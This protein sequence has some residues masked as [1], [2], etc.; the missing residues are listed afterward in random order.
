[1]PPCQAGDDGERPLLEWL[2]SAVVGDVQDL[3]SSWND[4]CKLAALVDYL[5]PGLI[6][7]HASLDPDQRLEN[8]KRVMDLAERH[9]NIPQ[10]MHPED[11]AVDKPDK[12]STM[13]YLSQ[14]CCPNSVGEKTLLD[15]VRRKLPHLNI[16]NFTT[17]WVNGRALGALT[18]VACTF[19]P[20]TSDS[21]PVGLC[22][23]AMVAAESHLLVRKILQP[24]EFTNPH[25][26][27]RLRMAHIVDMYHAMQPPRILETHVPERAGAGQEIVVELEVPEKGRLE[28]SASGTV[29][30]PAT[31]T[32][33]GT[34]ADRS[35]VKIA[36][37][38]RDK[39]TVSIVHDDQVIRGCPFVIA[40]DSFS[41]SHIQTS[42]PRKVGDTCSLTFDTSEIDGKQ[43]EVQAM[44]KTSGEMKLTMDH[45]TE[46]RCVV[47]FLPP[48]PDT[49]TLTVSVEGKPVKES[50]F[51]LPLLNLVEPWKVECGEVVS[52][53]VGSPVSMAIDCKKA[54]RG[55]ATANCT[56]KSSGDVPVRI[57]TTDDSPSAIMFTPSSD[58]L[59]LLR[60]MYEGAEVP[61]SPWCIDFRN[62]PPQPGKVRVVDTPT[63]SLEVGK[64]LS[65]VFDTSDAGSGQLTATCSGSVCGNVPVIVITEDLSRF[66]VNLVPMEQDN[67]FVSVFWAGDMIPGA[68]FQISFGCK[69]VDA[70]KCKLV[71]LQGNE[72]LVKVR[73]SLLAL[74]GR[75]IAL[76][77][78][79]AGAGKSTLE[80]KAVG[81]AGETKMDIQQ[82]SDNPDM[83]AVSYTPLALGNHRLNLIWGGNPI[84]CLPLYFEVVSPQ[85]FPVG[86]PI[87]V[88]LSLEGKKKDLNGEAVLQREG[89]PD[90]VMATVSKSN[91]KQVVLSLETSLMEP[92][93]YLLHV[94][95]KYRE[96]PNSPV[97]LVYG[98][99]DA[100]RTGN[101]PQEEGGAAAEITE[102]TTSGG[103]SDDT[104]KLQ[105]PPPPSVSPD[106][107]PT[108]PGPKET[109]PEPEATTA[110]HSVDGPLPVTASS[111]TP[112]DAPDDVH[113]KPAEDQRE[114]SA[115]GVDMQPIEPISG[116][117]LEL[118][119]VS[120]LTY[121]LSSTVKL[122]L[123]SNAKKND[124]K[125]HAVLK[126][127]GSQHRVK[128][129]KADGKTIS[130]SMQ[131]KE[132][133]TYLVHVL[134]TGQE[135]E[136]SPLVVEYGVDR[137]T[138]PPTEKEMS[139]RPG[140]SSPHSTH[141]LPHEKS[142]THD[143]LH[144]GSL[145]PR[146]YSMGHEKPTVM[147]TTPSGSIK[148]G[149]L[150]EEHINTSPV[151][152]ALVKD[153]AK[154]TTP[155][156]RETT[157]LPP[158]VEL[159]TEHVVE[160]L[161]ASSVLL[162]GEEGAEEG[163]EGT[164]T[165][166][167]KEEKVKSKTEK[168]K[169]KE[170][171]KDEEKAK[172]KEKKDEKKEEK[173]KKKEKKEAGLN[174]ED[175][176]FRV[177]IKMK[178][179]LHCEDLG[180]KDPQIVCD[181]PEAAKHAIVAAPQFGSN[182][183]WCEITPM[184][185]GEME[186]SILYDNFHILGSPFTV[187]VDPRGD[188]SQC[189]MVETASTC[190]RQLSDTLLFC[191]SVPESAGKGKL[192]AS[193][194][195]ATTHKHV[196]SLLTTG[197]SQHHYHVEFN[198]GQEL[199]YIMRVKY[200]ERHITGSPFTINLGDP[201][202]CRIQGDGIALAHIDEENTFVID[203]SD[204]GP[205]ELSVTIE[206]E[207]ETIQPKVT[208][209]G[210]KEYRVSYT[211][212][213]PG[214]YRVNVLWGGGHASNSPFHVSCIAASQFSIADTV[215]QAYAGGVA[216]IQVVTSAPVVRHMQLSVFAHPQGDISRIFS[217]EIEEAKGGYTCFL[218][219]TTAHL[220]PC[221]VHICWDGR[222]VQGSPYELNIAPPPSPTAFD[223]E[224]VECDSGDIEVH[225][226][227]PTDVFAMETLVATVENLLTGEEL[228]ATVT[229][230][231]N[232]KCS[233][234]LLPTMGGEYQLSILYAGTHIGSSP[235]VLTQGDP[236]Q[237]RASGV[238]LKVAKLGALTTFFVD[239]TGAGPG[240]LR[241]E[242]E[243][244][245]GSS[246]EPFVASGENRSEVSY[247]SNTAGVFKISLHWGEFQLPG[248]PFTMY[249][250]D[251]SKFSLQGPIPK[252]PY[253]GELMNLS[254]QAS[255]PV[256]PWELLTVTGKLLHRQQVFRGSVEAKKSRKEPKFQCSLTIPEMG[257][258][259][260]YVQCR[261]IDILGSP[262][263]VQM[264]PA[265]QPDKV[266]V[267]GAGLTDGALGLMRRFTINVEE[268]GHGNIGLRVEG[269]RG[270]FSI[271]MRRH[272]HLQH[273]IIAEYTPVYPGSYTIHLT[274]AGFV[275]PGSPYSVTIHN[276]RGE[277]E[278][279][280]E[281]VSVYTSSTF[282]FAISLTPASLAQQIGLVIS[283]F[284][285]DW[286]AHLPTP[287]G[288][289]GRGVGMAF[290]RL[291][292]NLSN[293][294]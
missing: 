18:A 193:V 149:F 223:L 191:V 152:D 127:D 267:S 289:V 242:M 199:E 27:P 271:N 126:T 221:V 177:G 270:G 61:G 131:P 115:G 92:G 169:K 85:Y 100:V 247:V 288:Q 71:G 213:R 38:V 266:R 76:Q 153:V 208:A 287:W 239:H 22:R 47:S 105:S 104:E 195:S 93:T 140:T 28:G 226:S 124:L 257:R 5:Q 33:E 165:M 119:A 181:P 108:S 280:L 185:V 292:S 272:E 106:S 6:P 157:P 194:K 215:C 232:Q 294:H 204:A 112:Q 74:A 34:A 164:G 41:L 253:V 142:H 261:G 259:A 245:G 160:E 192:V 210:E 103:A 23:E 125:V 134:K 37:P 256:K 113:K 176:D 15:F 255:A 258:Y 118:E 12:L 183:H 75:E 268:A 229:R 77:V 269:P 263:T 49:F 170:K 117:P 173:R 154:L 244:E 98:R 80:G 273:V 30:G 211:T 188:A 1:M 174:L 73:R 44:G 26:D 279:D 70:S 60:M 101:T 78:K 196:H 159:V 205:G 20:Q 216:S 8:V 59:Y 235:F 35:R 32:V 11:L 274:W 237:C 172:K 286:N 254:V 225:V 230:L 52:I 285:S 198:P 187:A 133:G 96:L 264:M 48:H 88:E 39:Y 218:N 121:P 67:Y 240:H 24:S 178:Y 138:E 97:L 250:V 283:L 290:S 151:E 16:T 246:I 175:Q 82:N 139:P 203:G 217:G 284:S 201:T 136:G 234:H 109:A 265:P 243:G 276:H 114:T 21:S 236:S 129:D 207:R 69:P 251:P 122:Q 86:G 197:V 182:T 110:G 56:G 130:L 144:E 227:G 147:I 161:H 25:L 166:G 224:A 233:I 53:G 228:Q 248:S 252:K 200:D 55:V 87:S 58:D 57:V 31:V 168:K 3:A 66:R 158:G 94:Y 282:L 95:S 51:V 135:L 40:L 116:S 202:K 81:P 212:R 29:S 186:V 162:G 180:S 222:D 241:V 231:T 9:L 83:W 293:V 184:R 120:S 13:T 148:D 220:G 46:D 156:P 260:V 206:G 281:W 146:S 219:P 45:S 128:I 107:E 17:D 43:M 63:G 10:V 64:V 54:G 19:D 50:P 42:M 249:T 111:P 99:E 171:T 89:M 155:P 145:P 14:F 262:F 102:A 167:R 36:V 62:I 163:S 137:H 68:P 65:V 143:S 189:H 141:S 275:V 4:G 278:E 179:K 84:P 123:A 150:G 214:Q 90:K 79:S 72:T 238:G 190:E 291:L 209:T 277:E 91:N 2:K 7:D 132:P